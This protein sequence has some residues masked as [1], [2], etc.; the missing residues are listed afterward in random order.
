VRH[1]DEWADGVSGSGLHAGR[2]Q[3]RP[4][5]RRMEIDFLSRM[6]V[7]EKWM[8]DYRPSPEIL[9]AYRVEAANIGLLRIL[10]RFQFGFY[11]LMH[12]RAPRFVEAGFG[13][14][15]AG[16]P[17]DVPSIVFPTLG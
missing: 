1:V 17:N 5:R 10:F 9:S 6:K 4:N 15:L 8:G 7:V 14:R 16:Y 3:R 11:G 13:G 12:D 2:G